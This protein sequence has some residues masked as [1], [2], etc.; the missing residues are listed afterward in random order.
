M[1][2]V[3]NQAAAKMTVAQWR[4]EVYRPWKES[5]VA[6]LQEQQG[7]MEKIK[8]NAESLQTIVGLLLD[9]KNRQAMMA[10]NALQLHPK[11]VDLQLSGDGQALTL[12]AS[13]GHVQVLRMD[14]LIKELESLLGS[15]AA[16]A[17]APG[18]N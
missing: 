18:G 17:A 2:E 14:D 15:G 3:K 4:D 5:V 16:P 6:Y 1:N 10:W 9:G 11:L 12:K 7:N 8:N 13:D